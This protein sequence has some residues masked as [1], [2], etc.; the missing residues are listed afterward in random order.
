MSITTPVSASG[1]LQLRL[2]FATEL[3]R[4]EKPLKPE[5]SKFAS[6]TVEISEQAIKKQQ[7]EMKT[8]TSK[9]IE[10]I[11]IDV[12]RVSSTIGRASSVGGLTNNQATELYNEISKL[13]KA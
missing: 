2:E 9:E 1:N 12:I 13:L 7:M 8:E 6:Y 4:Q 3:A 11:A 5:I 10:E